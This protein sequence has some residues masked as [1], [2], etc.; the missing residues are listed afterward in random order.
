[1]KRELSTISKMY[2]HDRG[3]TILSQQIQSLVHLGPSKY[4]IGQVQMEMC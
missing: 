2:D 3:A 1:M 4:Y